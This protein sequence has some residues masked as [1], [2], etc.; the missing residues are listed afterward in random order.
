MS[1]VLKGVIRNGRVVADEPMD[2]PEGTAVVV[3]S[4]ATGRDDDPVPSEEIARVLAAVQR[5]Q[6]MDIPYA[7]GNELDDWERK[8][9]QRGI[10]HTDAEDVFH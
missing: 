7:V 3:A 5:L 10:D 2:W 6:P 4:E 1:A 8:H 9:N